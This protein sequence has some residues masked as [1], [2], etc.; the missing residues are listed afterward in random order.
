[1]EESRDAVIFPTQQTKRE[2][3]EREKQVRY[4]RCPV[5]RTMT[6]RWNFA[7]ISGVIIDSCRDHGI[8]FDAGEIEKVMGFIA[9]GGLQKAK[10]IEIEKMKSEEEL[11]R[12]RNNPATSGAMGVPYPIPQDDPWQGFGVID[13]VGE[14]FGFL[15]DHYR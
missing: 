6:N 5:C 12:L 10:N 15:K 7:R 3:V 13:M 2:P 14:L 8:W 11:M 1:M 4:V 9:R